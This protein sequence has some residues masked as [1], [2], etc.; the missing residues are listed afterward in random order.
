MFVSRLLVFLQFSFL[1]ILFLPF[2]L[3]PVQYSWIASFVCLSLALKL[4]LYTSMHNKVGNFNIVPEIKQGCQ[5]IKTGPYSYI[6]HPMYTAVL[7]VGLGALFY[8]F[9]WFK[10]GV[11]LALVLVM[12]IKAN[13]EEKYW[14][15][16]LA[17]YKEYKQKTKMFIPFV[18]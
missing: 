18:L 3:V 11:F 6:R 15:A 16:S 14:C 10:L 8:G 4:L 13:K 2:F 9:A 12:F 7:L 1:L 5:L 17:E